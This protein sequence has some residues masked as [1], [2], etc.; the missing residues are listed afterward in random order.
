M[1][2]P[3]LQRVNEYRA[4][5]KK[6]LLDPC[7]LEKFIKQNHGEIMDCVEGCLLDSLLIATPRGVAAIYEKYETAWSSIFL[8]E[9]EKDPA[10]AVCRNWDEFADLCRAEEE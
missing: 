1:F 7:K 10:R 3:Y 9:W 2:R 6:F 8:V 5:V 4:P